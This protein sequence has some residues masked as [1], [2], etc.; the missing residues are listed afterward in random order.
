MNGGR[1]KRVTG[2]LTGLVAA[3]LL[4]GFPI[5]SAAATGEANQLCE[6]KTIKASFE[7]P[8]EGLIKNLQELLITDHFL[9]GEPDGKLDE[10][11]L[12]ALESFC[13]KVA[14]KDENVPH[15]DAAEI[16]DEPSDLTPASTFYC[17]CR[18]ALVDFRTVAGKANQS[19]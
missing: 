5:Q 4:I 17:D 16:A 6:I 15:G 9:D 12:A 1:A 2:R 3:C 18:E 14:S 11:T 7:S 13:L 19:A 8:D 10:A